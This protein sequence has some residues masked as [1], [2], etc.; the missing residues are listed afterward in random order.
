M[1]TERIDLI[2]VDL[3][4]DESGWFFATSED[5]P[6]LFVSDPDKERVVRLLPQAIELLYEARL[7][8]QVK[9]VPLTQPASPPERESG[10]LPFATIP[11]Q[12]LAH[13]GTL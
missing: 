2:T 11:V 5:C 9:A 7:H 6:G 13:P 1:P 12:M 10:S 4:K 3:R 8:R